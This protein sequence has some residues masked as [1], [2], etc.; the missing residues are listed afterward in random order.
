M[1]EQAAIGYVTVCWAQLEHLLLH[2]TVDI[3]EAAK[4]PVPEHA[5]SLSFK[6]RLRALRTLIKETG[7]A[8]K[9]QQAL[10]GLLTKIGNAERSRNRITHGLWDWNQTNPDGLIASSYRMPFDFEERFDFQKLIK[11]AQQIGEINFSLAFP[12]GEKQ[13]LVH[14][15]RH[16][17]RISRLGAQA[18]RGKVLFPPHSPLPKIPEDT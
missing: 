18:L 4:V 17:R 15:A 13:A 14:C 1:E 6:K 16:A 2:V 9:R 10:L 8:A 3:A 12:R 7:G 11:L 5:T